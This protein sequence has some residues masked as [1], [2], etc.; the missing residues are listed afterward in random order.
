MSS[1]IVGRPLL[2]WE[3][4][5]LRLDLDILELLLNRALAASVEEI[6]RIQVGGEGHD[7]VIGADVAYKGL[8]ARLSVR[9]SELRLYRRFLGCR[10]NRLRG[11]LGLPIPAEWVARV[12]DRVPG[13]MVRLDPEDRILLVDLQ[14]W[15]PGWLELRVQEA[16]CDGRW[17]VLGVA[18][19][20]LHPRLGPPEAPASLD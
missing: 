8:P 5:T 19:G 4:L 20:L 1:A 7:L 16:R 15:L 3:G 18:P 9:L 12:L 10:V 17:L 11:P 14:R 2:T 13:G 6:R